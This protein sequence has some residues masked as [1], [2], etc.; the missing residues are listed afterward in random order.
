[1]TSCVL[2]ANHFG[3]DPNEFITLAGWPEIEVFKVK[4]VSADGLPPEA[5]EVALDIAKIA[6]A[7][8]RRQVADALKLLLSKHFDL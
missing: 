7:G 5:V 4:M 8:L 2:M 1:I 3:I 6:D